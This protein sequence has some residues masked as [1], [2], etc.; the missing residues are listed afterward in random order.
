[1][2]ITL[3]HRYFF[4][5]VANHTVLGWKFSCLSYKNH[6]CQLRP[7]IGPSIAI[8]LARYQTCWTGLTWQI[9]SALFAD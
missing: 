4:E 1:M 5:T 3:V 6:I 9:G 8:D 2:P 7:R